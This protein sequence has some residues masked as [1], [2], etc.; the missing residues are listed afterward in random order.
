MKTI[1]FDIENAPQH[2]KMFKDYNQGVVIKDL[3]VKYNATRHEI[4]K[5]IDIIKDK[6]KVINHA[7]KFAEFTGN[8]S[9]D[10]N[11]FVLCTNNS[12]VLKAYKL[13][14]GKEYNN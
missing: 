4:S 11:N 12:E 13:M 1:I 2:E 10:K 5:A 6:I 8:N 3:M 14:T 7:E 9:H